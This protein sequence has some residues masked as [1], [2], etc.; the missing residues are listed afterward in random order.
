MASPAQSCLGHRRHMR[1]YIFACGLHSSLLHLAQDDIWM[2][3]WLDASGQIN[4]LGGSGLHF[5]DALSHIALDTTPA[6]GWL[7]APPLPSQSISLAFGYHAACPLACPSSLAKSHFPM[8]TASQVFPSTLLSE[9]SL[10]TE[11]LAIPS[12]CVCC[13]RRWAEAAAPT[14]YTTAGKM[15][16]VGKQNIS[17]A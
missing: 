14:S 8:L 2:N 16:A 5:P 3:P 4:R 11:R 17:E 7:H 1:R 13:K 12:P 6:P 10:G 9:T 15:E